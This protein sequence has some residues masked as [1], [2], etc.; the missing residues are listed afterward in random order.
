MKRRACS[1]AELPQYLFREY[2]TGAELDAFVHHR[3]QEVLAFLAD[4][5]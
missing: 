3:R 4:D 2:A 5:C 1:A